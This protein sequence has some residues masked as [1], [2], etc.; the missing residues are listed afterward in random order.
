MN[1]PHLPGAQITSSFEE[2]PPIFWVG[3]PGRP[4]SNFGQAS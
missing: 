2:Y 1:G 3:T 4:K